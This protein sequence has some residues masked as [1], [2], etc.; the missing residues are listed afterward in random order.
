VSPGRSYAALQLAAVAAVSVLVGHWAGYVVAVPDAGVRETVLLD[1]GHTYWML[2]VKLALLLGVVSLA[3]SGFDALRRGLVRAAAPD[4]WTPA[5]ALF[6][7][8][9]I[10]LGSFTILEL[11]ERTLA[12]EPLAELTHH[13]VF[14][15]GLA[16][17]LV[18][19]PLGAL[20]LGWLGRAVRRIVAIVAL[21]HSAPP[22]AARVAWPALAEH[23][24]PRDWRG[25]F[26]SR[27]PPE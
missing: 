27:G 7:L 10:Q 11:S 5:R 22:R 14:F 3:A 13:N 1:S 18:V 12:G 8:V 19:A 17:Q 26:A 4:G 24:P 25:A 15:W 20:L 2:A 9:T 16:A 21:V 6:A 23:V